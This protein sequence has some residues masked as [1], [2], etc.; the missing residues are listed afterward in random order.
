MKAMQWIASLALS[1]MLPWASAQNYPSK[2][3]TIVVPFPPGGPTDITARTLAATLSTQLGQQFVIDNKPGAG[4]T[5]GS[6]FVAKAA[7]DGYTLLWGGTSTLAVAPN[8]YA[9]PPYEPLK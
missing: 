6:A 7:P 8:L 5:L 4:G 9:N 1:M 3:V 2:P